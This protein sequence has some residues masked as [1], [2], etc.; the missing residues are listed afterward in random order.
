MSRYKGRTSLKENEA[1]FP[2]HVEM[3]VPEGGFGDRLNAMHDW[4][5][6]RGISAVRGQGRREHERN[7]VTW[8][9]KDADTAA[10]FAAEF[11]TFTAKK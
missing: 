2:H 7:F 11:A 4:H 8:C 5:H 1:K 6:V 3:M 9:F 10:M